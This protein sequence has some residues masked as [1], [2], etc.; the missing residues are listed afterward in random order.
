MP[1]SS[2]DQLAVLPERRALAEK[3]LQYSFKD[4]QLLSRALCHRSA[5]NQGL[6]SNERLE[7]LGDAVLGML[8]S[9]FLY[10]GLKD[11]DEGELSKR[12]SKLISG[13]S[14]A[15]IAQ[16]LELGPLLVTG[17][18]QDLSATPNMEADILEALIGAIFLD[19]G[20]E[21]AQDFVIREVL[22][23]HSTGAGPSDGAP[24]GKK[25]DD[26][27]APPAAPQ[28]FDDPKSKLQHHTLRLRLGLPEYRV[29]DSTGPGHSLTF[30]M[31]VL[32]QGNPIGRGEGTSKKL[33]SQ[34]AARQALEALLASEEDTKKVDAAATPGA[35][36]AKKAAA[37]K[38]GKKAAKKSSKKSASKKSSS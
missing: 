3:R 7:F 1:D 13:E 21:A 24:A 37:K 18:G 17:K 26:K 8:A 2:P 34:A 5:H 20:L 36:P 38:S 23:E 4:Q 31:E 11:K 25:G 35:K 14:L 15:A 28:D 29:V 19:G 32:V 22:T 9:W 10:E 27:A 12:R 30:T 33:A 6:A 16:R